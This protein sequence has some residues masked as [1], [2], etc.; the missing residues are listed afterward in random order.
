MITY[1]F[2]W[3]F[4]SRS[5]ACQDSEVQEECLH[6]RPYKIDEWEKGKKLE[7]EANVWKVY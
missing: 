3:K 5:E 7:R 6:Q 2:E 4:A 1:K